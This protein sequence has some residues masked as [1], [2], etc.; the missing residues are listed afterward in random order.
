M[1]AMITIVVG[2]VLELE[3]AAALLVV[4]MAAGRPGR[5]NLLAGR[6]VIKPFA[7]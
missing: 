5:T 7:E 4:V 3:A 2:A 1:V 6:V